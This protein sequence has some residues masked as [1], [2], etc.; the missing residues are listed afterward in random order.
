MGND[1]ID[2]APL[3]LTELGKQ[4]RVHLERESFVTVSDEG[5]AL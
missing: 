3:F 1:C 4:A 5:L 2:H